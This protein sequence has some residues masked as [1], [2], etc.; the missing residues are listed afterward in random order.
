MPSTATGS[1][2]SGNTAVA[3]VVNAS[4]TTGQETP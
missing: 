2:S 3:W 4:A 1:G